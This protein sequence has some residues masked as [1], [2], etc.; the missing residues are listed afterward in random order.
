MIVNLPTADALNATALKLYFRAWH[1]IVHILLDFD[2]MYPN[3]ID[4]WID[5]LDD[6]YKNERAEYLEVAQE[7]LHAFASIAQQ[8]NELA[9]KARIATVSP[10]LLLLNSDVKLSGTADAIEFATLRTLDAVDLP[11]AVNTLTSM[12]VSEAYTQ[13]YSQMRIQRNQ[14][15]HLGNITAILNPIA[16]CAGLVDQYRELW[17]DRAWFSDRVDSTYVRESYFGGKHWSPRQSIMHLLEYDRLLIPAAEF[18][19]MFGVKKAD[20]KFGCFSC[21]DDW[22]VS[23]NGPGIEEVPTAFYSKSKKAMHCILCGADFA[24]KLKTC[25][26]CDGKFVADDSAEFGAGR[27]FTC[28]EG[29]TE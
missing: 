29:N 1:G 27:C 6:T 5:P 25:D 14:Y 9:L 8:A 23:R 3:S 20:V 26:A 7:D 15:T 2:E 17:S 12:P 28:G 24:A 16:M 10:Y 19:K 11:K 21:Q 22:A 4:D 13:R 18:K